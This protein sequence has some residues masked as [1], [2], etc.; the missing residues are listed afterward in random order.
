MEYRIVFVGKFSEI[1]KLSTAYPEIIPCLPLTI[2][3]FAEGEET[4]ILTTNPLK[5]CE[6]LNKPELHKRFSV[7][8]KDVIEIL[9]E[10]SRAP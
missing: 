2:I 1:R 10:K 3:L 7:W 5:R 6:F 8:E 4:L 9:N